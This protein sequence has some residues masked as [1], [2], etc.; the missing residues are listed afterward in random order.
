LR[1]KLFER[2]SHGARS[3]VNGAGRSGLA[4]AEECDESATL[5]RISHSAPRSGRWRRARDVAA[6]LAGCG[7]SC[8]GAGPRHGPGAMPRRSGKL[9]QSGPDLQTDRLSAGVPQENVLVLLHLSDEA[10]RHHRSR[11]TARLGALLSP[12]LVFRCGFPDTG[13][14][15]ESDRRVRK[16]RQGAWWRCGRRQAHADAHPSARR[17]HGAGKRTLRSFLAKPRAARTRSEIAAV[18]EQM[19]EH[20]SIE[21]ARRAARQLAGAALLEAVTAFRSVPDSPQKRF[22]LE[23]VLYVINRDR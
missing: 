11:L 1:P 17:L 19:L 13:R 6:R 16:V 2:P 10:W 23:M 8:A 22:V 4:K 21:F 7:G 5:I 18:Y 15:S 12:R 14:Y 3:P 9:V 20:G